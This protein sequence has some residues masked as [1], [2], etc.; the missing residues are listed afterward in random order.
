MKKHIKIDKKKRGD[1]VNIKGQILNNL[2]VLKD[3]VVIISIKQKE[4]DI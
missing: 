2:D 3:K 1:R 4:L